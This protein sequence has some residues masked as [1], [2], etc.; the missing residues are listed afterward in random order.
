MSGDTRVALDNL[1]TALRY[2][3][4]T[5]NVPESMMD[6]VVEVVIDHALDITNRAKEYSR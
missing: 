2:Y 4:R 6:S 1:K 5:R 3:A